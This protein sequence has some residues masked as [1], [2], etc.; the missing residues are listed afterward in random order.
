MHI[1]Q[2][3]PLVYKRNKINSFKDIVVQ[4]NKSTKYF[5]QYIEKFY[6]CNFSEF[7]RL[8]NYF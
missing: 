2:I 5:N 3:N 6:V 1:S 8:N 7:L 4:K